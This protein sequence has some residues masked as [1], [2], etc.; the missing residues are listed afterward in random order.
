MK[1]DAVDNERPVDGVRTLWQNQP[2]DGSPMS[3][4]DVRRKSEE[5]EK[6]TQR[7]LRAMYVIG[8]A[9]AG[10]PLILMWFLP[11]LRLALAYLV[12]TAAVLVFYVRRRSAAR[13]IS[14]DMTVA[15]GRAFYRQL[16]E[17]ERDFR[18]SSVK[19]FTIGPSLNI[20]VLTFA[21]VST[22]AFHAAP[23][24][25]AIIAVVLVTHVVVLTS[26]AK[27]LSAEARRYQSELNEI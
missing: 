18:R 10:L 17:R 13:A 7:R 12:L 24:A 27:K 9:N 22:R 26:I 14:P 2:V 4:S 6:K 5:L 3:A 19:W 23:A 8:A 20:I 11:E 25:L 1:E 16:L 21:Y 15:Q